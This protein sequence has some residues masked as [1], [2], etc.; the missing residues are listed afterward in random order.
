MHSHNLLI[1]CVILTLAYGLAPVSNACYLMQVRRMSVSP[2]F[3]YSM[4]IGAITGAIVGM[5]FPMFCFGLGAFRPGY[6]SGVLTMLYDFGYL[7]FIGSLGCFCVMWMAFGLAII[8]DENNILPKWLGYYT[9]WQ[10]VTELMAA[11]VWIVEIGALRLERPDDLLV[12]DDPLCLVADHRVRVHL[13]G[14][15]EPAR[16]RTRQRLA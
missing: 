9:I 14:D 16:G 7:A 15:Q 11:P 5:L 4:M 1:A 13:P 6:N 8:L 2:A 12:R 3:R 10:Y